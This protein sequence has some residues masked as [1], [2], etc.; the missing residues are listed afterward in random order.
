MRKKF[1]LIIAALAITVLTVWSVGAQ[2]D[3]AI[4]QELGAILAETDTFAD[5]LPQHPNYQ[6]GGWQSDGPIWHVEFYNESLDEWLGYGIMNRDTG[7]VFE[8][9]APKPLPTDLY[10]ELLPRVNA[11]V[12]QDDEVMGLMNQVPEAWDIYPDYNRW[13]QTWEVGFYRGVEGFV[14]KVS[15]DDAFDN[16]YIDQILDANMLS[17]DEALDNARDEATNLAYQVEGVWEALDG[18]SDWMTYT[19]DLGDG[20]WGVTFSEYDEELFYA[21]VNINEDTVLETSLAQ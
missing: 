15:F 9:F 3:E 8:A 11:F 6:T 18:H 1:T 20:V 7:E 10:N 16:I 2:D 21:V 14:V 5:W 4:L 12:M 17:E 19:E 13:E